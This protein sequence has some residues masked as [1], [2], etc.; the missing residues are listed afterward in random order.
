MNG[1]DV[2]H[3]NG[4]IANVVNIPDFMIIRAGYGYHMDNNF[5]A[6]YT[7]CKNHG[8]PVGAYW[9]S[10]AKTPEQAEKEYAV[11]AEVVNGCKFELPVFYDLEEPIH[12]HKENFEP[13]A[14]AW[15]SKA[16]AANFW[17]GVYASESVL[18][19]YTTADFRNRYTIWCAKWSANPPSIRWDIWQYSDT[20]GKLDKNRTSKD[21]PTAIKN[22]HKNG[23]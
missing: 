8:I 7:F 15:L 2:S 1:I 10:Y 9:Y 19:D 16:E 22:A 14:K 4:N 18:K 6:N 3:H 11:F 23:Y 21:F 5:T 12:K 20:N 17:A 13:I